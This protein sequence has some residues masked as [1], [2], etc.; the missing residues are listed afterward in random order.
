MKEKVEKR[1]VVPDVQAFMECG[2]VSFAVYR[3]DDARD[4]RWEVHIMNDGVRFS[5]LGYVKE[6]RALRAF[7]IAVLR[8]LQM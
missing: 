2:N 6:G 3:F 1:Q 5:R 7:A 4:N 8:F